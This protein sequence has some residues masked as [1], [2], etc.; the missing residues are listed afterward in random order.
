MNYTTS[1]LQNITIPNFKLLDTS[2]SNMKFSGVNVS[3]VGINIQLNQNSVVVD[4]TNIGGT[5]S[6]HAE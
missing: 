2:Y 5:F 3:N 1:L 6:G 4:I